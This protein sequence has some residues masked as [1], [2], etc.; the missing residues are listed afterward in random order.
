MAAG[1]AWATG[2]GLAA[3][4]TAHAHVTYRDL[5]RPPVLVTTTFGGS[6]IADPCAGWARGCQSSNGFTRYGWLK[7]TEPTL[8]DSHQLTVAA[9]FWKFHLD[10]TTDVVITVVQGQAGLDPA[11]SVYRGL[12]PDMGHDDTAVDPLNPGDGAGCAAA[13]PVD[14]HAAPYTYQ[15]HDGFRDTQGG[16]TTGGLTACRLT[17]AYVGQFDAFARWSL[18]NLTGTWGEIRYV[19]S[20]SATPFTGHDGGA[21]L[22]GNHLVAAGTGE[23]LALTLEA[24]DY[25]IAAGGEACATAVTTCTSPRRYSPSSCRS[26]PAASVQ[27]GRTSVWSRA[28]QRVCSDA[29]GGGSAHSSR[30]C[31][32]A[33]SASRARRSS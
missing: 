3:S 15:V 4:A 9:E 1:I 26:A 28:S 21:H 6:A 10:H 30:W 8:G 32:Q 18:A 31:S 7:G 24:G 22:D 29:P 11:I 33:S 13:S 14:T 27:A 12:L 17:A 19:A 23:Q 25:T 5:D 20:V 2:V 16:A